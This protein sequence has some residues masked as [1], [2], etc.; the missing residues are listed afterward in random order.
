M[1]MEPRLDSVVLDPRES[2]PTYSS[3]PK[4][5]IVIIRILIF[6]LHQQLHPCLRFVKYLLSIK[7]LQVEASSK[8]EL[9]VVS[10]WKVVN[11]EAWV[12]YMIDCV[13]SNL[14]VAVTSAY[15][16]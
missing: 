5:V 16:G 15:H 14:V 7:E 10:S 4:L 9:L 8:V 13:R 2:P 1:R 3:E 6:P 11:N 12:P